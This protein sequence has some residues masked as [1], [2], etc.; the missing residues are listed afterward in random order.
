MKQIVVVLDKNLVKVTQSIMPIDSKGWNGELAEDEKKF[1][2]IPLTLTFD[3]SKVVGD[4][5]ITKVIP[6]VEQAM[7]A[8]FIQA[9]EPLKHEANI[10]MEL[11]SHQEKYDKMVSL[12]PSWE[13]VAI[14]LSHEKK[15]RKAGK[16]NALLTQAMDLKAMLTHYRELVEPGKL[17]DIYQ[18]GFEI[19]E[20]EWI[21][22]K[23]K[24]E[25]EFLN[26]SE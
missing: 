4:L 12:V 9:R 15:S 3:L 18:R 8:Y 2:Q 21:E 19:P 6:L 24:V 22:K 26:A 20:S 11:K 13:K 25:A 14:L 23:G 10:G 16:V 7:D 5:V 17:L 1:E